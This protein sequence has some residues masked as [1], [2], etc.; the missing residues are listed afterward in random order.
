MV[1][2]EFRAP[3]RAPI[4]TPERGALPNAWPRA[5]IRFLE[6]RP[7]F[8]CRNPGRAGSRDAHRIPEEPETEDP[9]GLPA[10][11]SRKK[12]TAAGGMRD[13]AARDWAEDS[14]AGD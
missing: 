2:R 14:E 9:A 5:R 6:V 3:G 11:G 1:I 4:Y 7:K 10:R 13:P 8:Q 12:G